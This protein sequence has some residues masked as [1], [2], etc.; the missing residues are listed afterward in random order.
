MNRIEVGEN[1]PHAGPVMFAADVL[2]RPLVLIRTHKWKLLLGGIVAMLLISPVE[3]VYDDQDGII[4]PLMAVILFAVALGTSR[5][6]RTLL[7]LTALIVVWLTISLIT[8]G[9][10]LFVGHN[11]PIAPLLFL[12]LLA[13]V[14]GLLL[15]WLV[16][17]V[18]IDAEVL[19]AAVCGYLLIGLLWTALDALSLRLDP[20]AFS[21]TD[22]A[23]VKLGDLLY[24]SYSTLTTVAFG[25]II[26]RNPFI[27]MVTLIEA[28]VGIFYNII[29][30]ARFVGMY[31]LRPRP[32]GSLVHEH[33]DRPSIQETDLP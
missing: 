33:A 19:C 3:R 30:I 11:N 10:G 28:I 7:A 1:L 26:P 16:N 17:S 2:F 23:S 14:F 24:F 29:V 4:S 13:M 21:A 22:H 12:V 9:S 32:M 8:E 15:R 31:G 27:R 25:D 18:L 6:K 5:K 20:Q